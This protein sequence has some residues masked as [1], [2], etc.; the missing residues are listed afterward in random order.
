MID[1]ARFKKENV[2]DNTKYRNL[3]KLYKCQ[4]GLT[5]ANNKLYKCQ[6][7]LTAANNKLYKFRR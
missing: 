4:R 3:G 2:A 7:G 6:R 1:S 5:A